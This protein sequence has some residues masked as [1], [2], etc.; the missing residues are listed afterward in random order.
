MPVVAE[1]QLGTLIGERVP[2]K[3]FQRLVVVG[4]AL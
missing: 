1:M 3:L 4:D 2:R